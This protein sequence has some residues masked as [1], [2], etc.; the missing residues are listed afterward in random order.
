MD[1]YFSCPTTDLEQ[2]EANL[3]SQGWPI[4]SKTTY[5]VTTDWRPLRLSAMA[6]VLAGSA[7]YLVRLV[8][9]K[10]S[11]G[12]RFGVFQSLGGSAVGFQGTAQRE[13][14]WYPISTAQVKDDDARNQLN[15]FRRAVCGGEDH[16]SGNEEYLTSKKRKKAPAN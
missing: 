1:A 9:G 5:Q 7:S 12:I 16:F 13:A 14:D 10:S 6:T 3:A 15:S 4:Q 8:V 2:A 11:S